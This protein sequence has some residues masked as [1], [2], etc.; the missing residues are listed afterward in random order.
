L[1][2]GNRKTNIKGE[3]I[4]SFVFRDNR[5]ADSIPSNLPITF[6]PIERSKNPPKTEIS[7]GL[8]DLNP[9]YNPINH[10][11]LKI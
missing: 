8:I 2:T 11:K 9:K 1:T 5:T 7:R 4:R 3:T 6:N 10:R